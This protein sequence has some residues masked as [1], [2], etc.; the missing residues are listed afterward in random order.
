MP[1]NPAAN[2]TYSP[3][4]RNADGP[5]KKS[6]T[7]KTGYMIA[8]LFALLFV[9]FAGYR[10]YSRYAVPTT[11]FDFSKTGMSDF[12]NGAY[13][14]SKAF[15]KHINPYAADVCDR[16][17][18]SRSTPPYS[19]VVFILYQPFTWL[20]LPTADIA[21][22]GANLLAIAGL[23]WCTVTAIRRLVKPDSDCLLNWFGD[24]RLVAIWAFGLIMLSR[25]GHITMFTGYFTVQLVIGTLMS[26]HYARSKPWLAGVGMLLASGKPTYIIPLMILMFFRRDYKA[27][28]IGFVLCAL[29]AGA[30]LGWLASNTSLTEVVEGIRQGQEAFSTDT[31]ELP[32]NTWT[33][34]DALGVVSKINQLNPPIWQVLA[35]ML[36]VLVPIGGLIWR[37]RER[38]TNQESFGLTAT[39]SCL[40]LLVAIYHHSYDAML[41]LPVWLGLVFGGQP[42]F[43]WL[44]KWQRYGLTG[45]LTVPVLNYA[46]TLRFRELFQFENTSTAWNAITAANGVCLLIALLIVMLASLRKPATLVA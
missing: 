42:M 17:A 39:I 12:H 31:T 36:L 4:S 1:N 43:S 18:M 15:A 29:V 35:G 14:P 8:I 9:S 5:L 45:L 37:I 27:L 44:G 32:V 7:G 26:L 40:A 30:G 34:L 33:R 11:V 21:F 19:P 13:F 2:E 6:L 41:V 28:V 22:F 20:D 10:A 46:A 23:A 25:S 3:A 24:D 16:Y 38:E